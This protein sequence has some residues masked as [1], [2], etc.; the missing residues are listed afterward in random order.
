MQTTKLVKISSF[1]EIP[2]SN[3]QYPVEFIENSTSRAFRTELPKYGTKSNCNL[4]Q[5][6]TVEK[7]LI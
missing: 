6:F 2:D 5:D 4:I 7:F 1:T 3:N